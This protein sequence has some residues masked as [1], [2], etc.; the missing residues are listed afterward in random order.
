MF[1]MPSLLL[2]PLAAAVTKMT[3]ALVLIVGF[4]YL[5]S[6]G[7]VKGESTN[8]GGAK[9]S[10]LKRS[11]SFTKEQHYMV[12]YYVFGYFW[13]LEFCNAMNLFV[14]S[15]AVT[16]WFYKPRQGN[17][18]MIPRGAV[19]RGFCNGMTYHI[20]SLAFGALVVSVCQVFRLIFEL[21]S[22]NRRNRMRPRLQWQGAFPVA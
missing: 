8:I 22:Q 5:L 1:E 2:Q 12:W 18:K 15:F 11:F 17:K 16:M 14:T 10:G 20:G 9:V 21:L 3:I 19:F 7:N 6:C 4:M 13:A